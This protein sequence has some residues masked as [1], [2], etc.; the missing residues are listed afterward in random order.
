MATC[1]LERDEYF[2]TVHTV[3]AAGRNTQRQIDYVMRRLK[4][5]DAAQKELLA[6]L[7]RLISQ[8]TSE[9]LQGVLAVKCGCSDC[10]EVLAV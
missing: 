4:A 6:E 3:K 5:G 7:D 9:I 1:L 10:L 2:E 8:S